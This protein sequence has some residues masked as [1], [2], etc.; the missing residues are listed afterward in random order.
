M[1][2]WYSIVNFIHVCLRFSTVICPASLRFTIVAVLDGV[3]LIGPLPGVEGLMVAASHEGSGLCMVCFSCCSMCTCSI[4]RSQIGYYWFLSVRYEPNRAFK[5]FTT[6]TLATY[7]NILSVLS[8]FWSSIAKFAYQNELGL[9]W[10][11]LVIPHESLIE[12]DLLW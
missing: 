5:V 1:V 3:P 11:M 12:S 2:T 10:R 7:F 8:V 4:Y 9:Q 6:E